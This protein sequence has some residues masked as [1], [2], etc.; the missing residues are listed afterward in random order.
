MATQPPLTHASDAQLSA[1]VEAHFNSWFRS[2]AGVLGGDLEETPR[3]SRYH[4]APGS[5]IFKGVW[6]ARLTPGEADAA[7]DD[8]I[9]WYKAR[10]APFCFWWVGHGAQPTDLGERLLAH[11]FSVFEKDATAMV[12]DFDQ[13]NWDNPRPVDLRLEPVMNETQLQQ[14]KQTFLE[15][16]D[17]PEWA[18]QAWV[19]ATHTVGFGRAPWHLLL[20][21]LSGEPVCFGLLYCGAGVAGL[22]GLGTRPAYR[23]QGIASAMQLERL[24]LARNMGYHY[25]VLTASEMGRSP[26]LKLGF[27][28]TGRRVS[29]YIWRNE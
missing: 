2:M 29:R 24:R 13:L 21:T 16:F 12:A 11:G 1:A 10:N 28:D 4:C 20:G 14:W 22:N 7:I 6:G 26:Y 8:T 19:D 15:S 25:A 9:A 18:G 17:I 3:L 5:P 23:R 27:Q